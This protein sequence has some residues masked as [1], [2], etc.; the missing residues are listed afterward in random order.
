MLLVVCGGG[1]VVWVGLWG[2]CWSVGLVVVVL[3]EGCG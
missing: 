2:Y 1:G 3:E